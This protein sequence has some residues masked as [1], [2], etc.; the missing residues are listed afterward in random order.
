MGIARNLVHH[1][2]YHHQKIWWQTWPAVHVSVTPGPSKL[3]K[4]VDSCSG[5]GVHYLVLFSWENWSDFW[6]VT[7]SVKYYEIIIL[8]L[9]SGPRGGLLPSPILTLHVTR[10]LEQC[11]VNSTPDWLFNTTSGFNYFWWFWNKICFLNIEKISG[12]LLKQHCSFT[13]TTCT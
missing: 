6:R 12:V 10:V 5:P 3:E 13:L 1:P 2:P 7:I 4:V 11:C 9:G 8:D